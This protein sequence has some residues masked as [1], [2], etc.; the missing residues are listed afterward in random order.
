MLKT[1]GRQR[2]LYEP[3][4]TQAVGRSI[5]LRRFLSILRLTGLAWLPFFQD[6]MYLGDLREEDVAEGTGHCHANT[7]DTW[8]Y[9]LE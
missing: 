1:R 9:L 5:A 2:A 6:E 4:H 3:A 7:W 8:L